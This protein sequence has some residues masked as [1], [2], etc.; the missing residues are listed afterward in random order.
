MKCDITK[1]GAL[2]KL[3]RTDHLVIIANL[4]YLKTEAWKNLDGSIRK[5]EPK[6][7]LL[8]G[9]DGLNH[10]RALMKQ[11][12]EADLKPD[13]LALEADPPQFPLLKKIVQAF[14]PKYRLETHKDLH[15][16]DRV[17]VAN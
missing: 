1:P 16:D 13:L 10:Y 7:A 15:G 3:P 6:K 11:L 8:S 14:N 2:K 12:K 4:P 5:F 9:K 17:L